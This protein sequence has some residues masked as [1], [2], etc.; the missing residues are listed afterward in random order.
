MALISLFNITECSAFSTEC[1]I[2][3]LLDRLN[4]FCTIICYCCG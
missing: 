3:V 1:L 2:Y 4:W